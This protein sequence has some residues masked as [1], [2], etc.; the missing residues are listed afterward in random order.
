MRY[1]N[2]KTGVLSFHVLP[3]LTCSE[4]SEC[5]VHRDSNVPGILLKNYQTSITS[6]AT[7]GDFPLI[8]C[9][10]IVS[11]PLWSSLPHVILHLSWA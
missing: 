11:F 3:N 9:S 2:R 1:K 6:V 7:L 8:A 10:Q 5:T 4:V